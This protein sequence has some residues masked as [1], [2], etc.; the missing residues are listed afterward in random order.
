[1]VAIRPESWHRYRNPAVEVHAHG[2]LAVHAP[3]VAEAPSQ[4]ADSR[5]IWAA[6]DRSRLL[7][8]REHR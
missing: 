3:V 6:T 5:P 7:S 4:A 8:S 2:A 1:M